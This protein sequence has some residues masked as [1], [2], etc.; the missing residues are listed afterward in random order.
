MP[1]RRRRGTSGPAPGRSECR[2]GQPR[3]Q[4]LRGDL[5]P[6]VGEHDRAGHPVAAVRPVRQWR[7]SG[8]GSLD[9]QPALVGVRADRLVPQE[10]AGPAVGGEEPPLCLPPL[11]PPGFELTPAA[12]RLWRAYFRSRSWLPPLHT[13]TAPTS[14][15]AGPRRPGGPSVPGG[16]HLL[17][18]PFRLWVAWPRSPPSLPLACREGE[19]GLDRLDAGPERGPP[20]HQVPAAACQASSDV[21]VIAPAHR[22]LRRWESAPSS[23]PSSTRP[24]PSHPGVPHGIAPRD[25]PRPATPGATRLPAAPPRPPR[26][27]AGWCTY[28]R[29]RRVGRDKRLRDLAHNTAQP[30]TAGGTDPDGLRADAS[31]LRCTRPP[32]APGSSPTGG[33]TSGHRTRSAPRSCPAPGHR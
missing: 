9:L 18:V 31:V 2:T 19:A 33:R 14:S 6:P 4:G 20:G 24:G 8:A 30:V 7:P 26:T 23:V 1:A 15:P 5:I 17:S 22:E 29:P 12:C 32:S 27:P 16:R 10:L 25:P 3:W 13:A 21:R 28:P 11:A